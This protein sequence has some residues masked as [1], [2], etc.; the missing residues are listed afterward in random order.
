MRFRRVAADTN[1][2]PHDAIAKRSTSPHMNFRFLL[3]EALIDLGTKLA[4]FGTALASP[5]VTTVTTPT[6]ARH[7]MNIPADPSLLVGPWKNTP[8]VPLVQ[9]TIPMPIPDPSRITPGGTIADQVAALV[10]SHNSALPFVNGL[11]PD[12]RQGT[13]EDT[14][15]RIH[16]ITPDDSK[17]IADAILKYT[18]DGHALDLPF[19][20]AQIAIESAFDPIAQM[21]NFRGSNPNKVLEG[22]DM[23]LCQLKLLYLVGAKAADGTEVHNDF[24]AQDFALNIDHAIPYFVTKLLGLLLYADQQIPKLSATVNPKFKNRYYFAAGAYNFGETGILKEI[25]TGQDL[26]HCAHVANLCTNFAKVLGM[27]NVFAPPVV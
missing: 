9:G 16:S 10:L 26:S 18:I 19:A 20:M 3:G 7:V 22:Y 4:N 12:P 25:S 27:P 6:P 21:G 8:I 17:R 24:Q 5:D 1:A 11:V 14:G 13:S 23:G 2:I 15:S